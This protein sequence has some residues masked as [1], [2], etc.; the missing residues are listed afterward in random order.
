MSK[1]KPKPREMDW[2]VIGIVLLM[3][4]FSL[5][6]YWTVAELSASSIG[7]IYIEDPE[8]VPSTFAVAIGES[9]AEWR[10]CEG[11]VRLKNDFL[12][13]NELKQPSTSSHEWVKDAYDPLCGDCCFSLG[14]FV[15]LS[16]GE[17]FNSQDTNCVLDVLGRPIVPDNR[18][19]DCVRKTSYS[20]SQDTLYCNLRGCT[21]KMPLESEDCRNVLELAQD[22]VVEA[23]LSPPVAVVRHD[24]VLF[25]LIHFP[26]GDENRTYGE[27]GDSIC[28]AK[29]GAVS[30]PVDC[31]KP[32][33]SDSYVVGR[34][35]QKNMR[36]HAQVTA[37]QTREAPAVSDAFQAALED[38]GKLITPRER[39]QEFLGEL[40][41]NYDLWKAR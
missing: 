10:T 3:A 20:L 11:C 36:I 7:E 29:E 14:D 27:C 15:V 30:C 39:V 6:I 16:P 17:I 2:G 34:V 12:N 40:Q 28:S 9:D 33:P 23:E 4:A 31:D 41:A 37:L 24:G 35:V 5:Y 25:S 26:N 19:M 18:T 32:Q 8:N 38:P 1:K 21:T 13:I 22:L